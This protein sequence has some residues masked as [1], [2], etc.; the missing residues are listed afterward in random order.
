MKKRINFRDLTIHRL[1]DDLGMTKESATNYYNRAYKSALASVKG[2]HRGMN[3]AREVYG[4]LFYQTVNTFELNGGGRLQ[5]NTIYTGS[6]NLALDISM[7]RMSNF[8][9]KYKDDKVLQNIKN[10]YQSGQ[11]TRHEFNEKIQKWKSTSQ[12]YLISGS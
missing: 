8:F 11:I 10:Q 9:D 7:N 2:K 1:Q 5:L 6:S 3:V 4:S 12:R